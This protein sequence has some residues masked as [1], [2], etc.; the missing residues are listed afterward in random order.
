MKRK[1]N[2]RWIWIR[3]RNS[4][5]S[6]VVWWPLVSTCSWDIGV[7]ILEE[8][9]WCRNIVRMST[10]ECFV[11]GCPLESG[12]ENRFTK[13]SRQEV[14]REAEGTTDGMKLSV[15]DTGISNNW[16]RGRGGEG[17]T[18]D[19]SS[20]IEL[21]GATTRGSSPTPKLAA[22]IN[23]LTPLD[24]RLW[25]LL[26]SVPGDFVASW[27][28]F[29]ELRREFSINPWQAR[30]GVGGTTISSLLSCGGSSNLGGSYSEL[31][32]SFPTR[33]KTSNL[34]RT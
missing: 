28:L 26:T 6:P 10:T 20:A 31:T 18:K 21:S 24:P 33:S 2:C 32:L 9:G 11:L 3:T 13:L 12:R 30:V 27:S 16:G 22:N 7:S 29:Q 1:R 15:G 17:A 34:Y 14:A 8:S 19:S 23:R 25:Y 4:S 5:A